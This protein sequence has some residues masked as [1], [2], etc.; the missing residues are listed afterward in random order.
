LGPSRGR[1]GADAR[2]R[3]NLLAAAAVYRLARTEA[4]V[5]A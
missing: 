1:A 4:A 3:P 5:S 2:L